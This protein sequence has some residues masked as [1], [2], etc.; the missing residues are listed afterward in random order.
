MYIVNCMTLMEKYH[1]QLLI[2]SIDLIHLMPYQFPGSCMQLSQSLKISALRCTLV[3][4]YTN[5]M[6]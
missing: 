6:N 2:H 4:A 3:A 5:K 1:G